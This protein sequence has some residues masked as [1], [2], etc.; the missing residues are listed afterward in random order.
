MY[1]TQNHVVTGLEFQLL[2]VLRSLFL[3][4]RRTFSFGSSATVPAASISSEE[5]LPGGL[6]EGSCG[7]K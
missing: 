3:D 5:G 1:D 6:L 2:S 7:R 4:A